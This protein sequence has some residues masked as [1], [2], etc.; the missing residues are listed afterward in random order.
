[1]SKGVLE[2]REQLNREAG[3]GEVLVR[4]RA[5]DVNNADLGQENSSI[6]DRVVQEFSIAAEA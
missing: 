1:V 6:G 3:A 2:I 5:A 4:V